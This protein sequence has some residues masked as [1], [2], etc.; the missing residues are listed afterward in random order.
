VSDGIHSKQAYSTLII[1]TDCECDCA[2]SIE[3]PCVVV[4]RWYRSTRCV[5][6]LTIWPFTTTS[7]RRSAICAVNSCGVSSDR[8]S[9]ATAST[10]HSSYLYWFNFAF[11]L[12]RVWRNNSILL[13]QCILCFVIFLDCIFTCCIFVERR[14]AIRDIC[15][16][17]NPLMGTL[18]WQNSGPLYNGTVAVDWWTVIFGTARTG[19]SGLQ[20]RPVPSLLYQ[21]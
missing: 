18:I 5:R 6:V 1:I 20:P 15:L 4:K 16:T 7:R 10:V 17:I 8:E 2:K 9:S 12:R 19:L 11:V 14:Y 13:L 21:M 3:E